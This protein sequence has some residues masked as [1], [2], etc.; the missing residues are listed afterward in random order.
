[1]RHQFLLLIL[2][3][4]LTIGT[5]VPFLSSSSH[6]TP[7]ASAGVDLGTTLV[8]I[9]F[10]NGVV[11]GAD[12]RTSVSGYVSHRYAHKIEKITPH[13][14]LA[15]SGSAADTQLVA[16]AVRQE[17]WDRHDRYGLTATVSQVA[18][19]LRAVAYE[20]TLG[21]SLLVAGRDHDGTI[22][23]FSIA[24]SGAM[25]EEELYAAAGSGSAF[26]L[27]HL[28]HHVGKR[29]KLE[30]QEAI[31]LCRQSVALAMERD[32]SSGGIIR[33]YVCKEEGIRQVTVYP[34]QSFG[35]EQSP[36]QWLSRALS[37]NASE[38]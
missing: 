8:A 14:L 35:D 32:G 7:T 9:K 22:R 12:S 21:V 20:N 15:R 37:T 23:I 19:W 4:I 30:E 24:A 27:G 36:S 34:N 18:H 3:Y 33:M 5:P 31:D 2:L 10:Q 29:R 6:H 13:C 11:V 16:H 25:I 38:L 28:D 17:C 26:V 1:M